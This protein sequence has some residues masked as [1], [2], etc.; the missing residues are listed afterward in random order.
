MGVSPSS[1]CDVNGCDVNGCGAVC[2]RSKRES[3]DAILQANKKRTRQSLLEGEGSTDGFNTGSLFYQKMVEYYDGKKRRRYNPISTDYI[4]HFDKIDQYTK[5]LV[6]GFINI[7]QSLL[8]HNNDYYK[9]PSH[10]YMLCLLY[11]SIPF[12]AESVEFDDKMPDIVNRVELTG[13]ST[14]Q[15]IWDKFDKHQIGILN[16]EKTFPKILYAYIA[17]YIKMKDRNATPPRYSALEPLCKSISMDIKRIVI[18]RKDNINGS[19]AGRGITKKEYE[20]N[21]ASYWRQV[22][23]DRKN[24]SSY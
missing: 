7:S 14:K 21:I 3:R 17:L 12:S 23:I 9:I 8:A 13:I 10:I 18:L 1:A 15:K 19:R 16:F 2:S 24:V 11:Y 4:Q 22:V 5:D 6:F 20:E